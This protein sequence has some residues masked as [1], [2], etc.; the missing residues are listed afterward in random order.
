MLKEFKP[1]YRRK[2]KDSLVFSC[3]MFFS[4]IKTKQTKQKAPKRLLCLPWSFSLSYAVSSFAIGHVTA[5]GRATKL[6]HIPRAGG[7]K[8]TKRE[9]WCQGMHVF[10]TTVLVKRITKTLPCQV[11]YK[12]FTYIISL[13]IRC[14]LCRI[15]CLKKLTWYYSFTKQ[16]RSYPAHYDQHWL[17]S[18]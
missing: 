18:C 17:M 5:L 3:F 6:K 14:L 2:A 7:K 8:E 11:K 1:H 4:C 13:Q 16:F 9:K 10:S 12:S 15:P